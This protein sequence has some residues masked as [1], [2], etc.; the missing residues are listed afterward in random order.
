MKVLLSIDQSTQGTKGLVWGLDGRL[1]GRADA[2]HRQ[3]VNERGWVSHDLD[4]IWAN[5]RRAAKAA[6]EAAGAHEVAALGLSNQRETA[7]C[8]DRSTGRP[9]C[10]AI[11]WQ[12]GRAEEIARRLIDHG[13]DPRAREI[14]GLPLSPFFSAPKYA[15]MLENEP[16]VREAAA[17]G[18]ACFGT[19]DS[20]LVWK[21]TEGRMYRTDA[22][23]ASRTGLMDLD[24]LTWSP[25]LLSAYGLRAAWLPEI[26]MSDGDYGQ[27]TLDGLLKHPAPIR[28]VL[29]DSHAALF[30][31]GCFAPYSAK[32]TYGTGSS[33]MMNAGA[34]RPAASGGVV[35]SLAWAMQGRPVYCL[36]GNINDT[37]AL[38]T[39]LIRD[40][41]LLQKPS[42][43]GPLAASLPD[44]GGVYLVP[45]FSGLGAPHF[46]SGARAAIVGMDRFTR[47]AHIVRAA[48]EAIAYQIA[49]VVREMEK[50]AGHALSRLCADGGPTRD[51]FLMRFQAG[52]LDRPLEISGIEEL[53]GAG[54]AYCAGIAGG[55]TDW[56]SL[57]SSRAVR[58]ATGDMTAQQ[59][60]RSMAGW[61]KAV[62][63]VI[64]Q[65]AKE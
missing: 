2:P 49:D 53:S 15:W 59:R 14:T 31:H 30:A 18:D 56:Q 61:R 8:W 64:A 33:V 40:M 19:I 25:E 47:R 38:I 63:W 52:L 46:C 55:F 57:S 41:E 45:A 10:R 27:T 50:A 26:A 21:L 5:V 13:L 24:S 3:W 22:S 6:L 48:E 37:G 51:D 58:T 65:S 36:E 28:G 12:C 29:G 1:L 11:V 44:N 62:Q 23:N 7:C 60:E 20:F 39:W 9:L 16:A 17:R 54:A 32:V 42:E 43:S 35:T 4:E 34:V